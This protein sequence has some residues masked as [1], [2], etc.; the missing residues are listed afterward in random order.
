M[1]YLHKYIYVCVNNIYKYDS[2]FNIITNTI[3][4]ARECLWE[5]KQYKK[6]SENPGLVT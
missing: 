6:Q 5:R 1:E 4:A 3:E 2:Y